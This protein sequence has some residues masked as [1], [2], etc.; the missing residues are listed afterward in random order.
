MQNNMNLFFL[1]K[2]DVSISCPITMVVPSHEPATIVGF[3]VLL[4]ATVNTELLFQNL[5]FLKIC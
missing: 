4:M 3:K 5:C 2:L 1:L